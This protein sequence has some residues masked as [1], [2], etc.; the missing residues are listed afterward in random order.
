MEKG[1]FAKGVVSV[2]LSGPQVKI[3]STYFGKGFGAG[4]LP[5]DMDGSIMEKLKAATDKGGNET[6]VM[7]FN[8]LDQADLG[9]V[10]GLP[11]ILRAVVKGLTDQ[12]SLLGQLIDRASV[13]KITSVVIG[14][15]A[16]DLSIIVLCCED[17]FF[18]AAIPAAPEIKEF[19]AKL[20]RAAVADKSGS[21]NVEVEIDL[22]NDTGLPCLQT[23]Q[24]AC[25]VMAGELL[26]VAAKL[27]TMMSPVKMFVAE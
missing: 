24:E 20:I 2:S 19:A 15:P 8:L 23:I 10:V 13:S 5:V 14:W 21:D 25:K 4:S 27:G 11:F 22:E 17:E 3:L 12:A 9:V 16:D 26:R 7:Q 1:K 18:A 6:A